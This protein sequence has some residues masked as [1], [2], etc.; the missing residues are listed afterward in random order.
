MSIQ[1]IDYLFPLTLLLNSIKSVNTNTLELGVK[2]AWAYNGSFVSGAEQSESIH[3]EPPSSRSIGQTRSKLLTTE[4]VIRALDAL[5]TSKVLL[6]NN[7][8]NDAKLSSN[9]GESLGS[10]DMNISPSLNK[11]FELEY[12]EPNDNRMNIIRNLSYQN[13]Y[14]TDGDHNVA[15]T[16][17]SNKLN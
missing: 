12:L 7:K 3:A 15:V 14:T 4:S 5:L 10:L 1:N 9:G 11:I 13:L 2:S 8:E 6:A 16:E 17:Q